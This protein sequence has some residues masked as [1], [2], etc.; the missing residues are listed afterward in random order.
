MHIPTYVPI[1]TTFIGING[2]IAFIL[3]YIV[4]KERMSTRIWHG[5]SEK[6]VN[7]QPKYLENP[8]S[9]AT[10][11][12]NYAQKS[13]VTKTSDDGL[14]LRKVRAYGNF[15]EHVPMALLFVLT[16]ELM[17]SPAWLLWLLSSAL[18]VGRIG[19]AW[20]LIKV[21]GPSPA[22]AIG[23]FLTCFVYIIGAGACVYYGVSAL[24]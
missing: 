1:S 21:Y 9:W 6:D 3:S 19:H 10:F 20:G 13:V 23:F 4:V 22:R 8:S 15:T 17:K 7:T 12:E 18:T 11:V 14:L 5:E 2:F 16:L 24:L